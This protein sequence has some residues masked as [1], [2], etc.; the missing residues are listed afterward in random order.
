MR[1]VEGTRTHANLKAAFAAEARANRL[2]LEFARQA[3]V[4]GYPETARLFRDTA[5]GEAS[6]ADGHLDYLMKAGDPVTG[7]PIGTTVE[8]LASAIAGESVE[9]IETYPLMAV[10][11]RQEGFPEIADWFE[12]VAK[13][14]G[15]HAQRFRRGI[16][17][18]QADS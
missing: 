6:H 10:T 3:D 18:F 8:N 17:S 13:A 11:A 5:E 1:S 14:E 12:K 16:L 2:Y 7:L 15:N 4:D 9:F